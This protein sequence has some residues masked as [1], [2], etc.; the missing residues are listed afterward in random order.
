MDK[1]GFLFTVT[2]FLILTYIL[3]SISVW[4]K[5]VE[6]S[7]RAYSE[8]YKESTVELAVEQITPA[9]VD[10]VT[11]I[12]MNRALFSLNDYSIAHPVK[13][14]TA[15]GN[16][17]AYISDALHSLLVNGTAPGSDFQDGVAMPD[18]GSSL[19]AWMS[20]LNASLLAI[21]VYASDFSVSDFSV[22]QGGIDTVD[23]GFN[24]SLKLKDYSNTSAV[25]RT[26]H[27][28]NSLDISGLVDPALARGSRDLVDDPHTAYRQFFFNK[29]IYGSP[30]TILVRQ[31]GNG[32]AGQGWVYGYLASA[33]QSGASALVPYANDVDLSQRRNYIITG[34]FPDIAA[35]GEAVY[36]GFAGYIVTDT[37]GSTTQCTVKSTGAVKKNELGTFNPIKYSGDACDQVSIDPSAGA[38]TSK[39]FILAHGF[40]TVNAQECPVFTGNETLG[41]CALITNAWLPS[42]VSGNPLKKLDS[43]SSGIYGVED[44]RDFVM[45]GYYTQDAAAPSYFQRMLPDSYSRNSS[46]GIE[47]FVIGQ[48]ANS[49]N[50]DLNSR[51]DRELFNSSIEGVK[52]MGLPGCR[53]YETCAD[54]PS[55]GIFAVS[56]EV[57]EAYGLD[58]LMCSGTRCG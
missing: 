36:G 42:D 37:P 6:T 15:A 32:Q 53:N 35:L 52:I 51:L 58:K 46:L 26:Y 38:A 47:T 13:D 9:K 40:D 56:K 25:T 2:V 10:N 16:E 54:T 50:Y 18:D 31:L 33:A 49:T 22:S 20:N 24:M 44:M 39:P 55:T 3:L 19:A 21:G 7:E 14:G 29:S 34:S 57:A 28:V 4:V 41:R 17:D 5:G 11:S 43:S 23:Y 27:I 1:K 12:I 8:F 48:Y 30:E 45:C